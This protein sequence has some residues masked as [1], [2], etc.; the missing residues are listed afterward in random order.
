MAVTVTTRQH[1]PRNLVVELDI[2]ADNTDAVIV[3]VSALG[4]TETLKL[5]EAQWAIEG[6]DALLEWDQDTDAA[7]LEMPAGSGVMFFTEGRKNPG[8]TGTTG[9]V[10]LTNSASVTAGTVV[11]KFKKK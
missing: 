5:V 3:D 11:L 7:L 6:D 8:G 10:L 2:A 1:G 4:I 9:D